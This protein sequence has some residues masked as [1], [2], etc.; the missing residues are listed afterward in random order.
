MRLRAQDRLEARAV[1]VVTTREALRDTQYAFD[2][3][4]RTYDRSNTENSVLYAMRAR[5]RAALERLVPSGGRVLDLGCGPGTDIVY[6]AAKGYRVTAIDASAAMI[7]EARRKVHA[8]CPAAEVD[9]RH[10]EIDRL[11]TL[12]MTARFDAAYSS[13]GPLNCV[14]DLSRAARAIASVIRPG[15][16]LIASVIGRA[17]PWEWALYAG[18]REWR[19]AFVRFAREPV[20]VPLEGRTVW[21]RYYSPRGFAVA[22]EQAGFERI[23]WRALGVLTPPP[24]MSAFADRHPMLLG[25]LGRTDDVIASWPVVRNF[26]DHFLIVMSR[27]ATR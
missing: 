13:F 27:A 19:R 14:A 15:G 25:V 3:V 23:W 26:G 2:G 18:R 20:P 22:F 17:C 24:Y 9:V 5:T 4:A 21:T 8:A 1:A 7:E 16:V 6:F 11:D 10:I 12:D